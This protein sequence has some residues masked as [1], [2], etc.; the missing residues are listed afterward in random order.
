MNLC[1]RKFSSLEDYVHHARTQIKKL[2]L[3]GDNCFVNG[4]PNS[5]Y[6]SI[7]HNKDPKSFEEA[8]EIVLRYQRTSK[9]DHNKPNEASGTKQSQFAGKRKTPNKFMDRDYKRQHPFCV[10]CKK[11]GHTKEQCRKLQWKE[12]DNKSKVVDH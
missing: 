12:H 4:L 6:H 3:E 9:K 2:G 5:D 11:K 7:V 1:S 10:F 8:V